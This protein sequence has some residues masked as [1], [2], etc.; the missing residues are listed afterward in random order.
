MLTMSYRLNPWLNDPKISVT[1]SM[2]TKH[3]PGE[4]L[5]PPEPNIEHLLG[6]RKVSKAK[7]RSAQGP[8]Q[9]KT[10]EEAYQASPA[11]KL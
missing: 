9:H 1:L 8:Q 7:P 11:G 2:P 3:R 4:P 5:D 6:D 10:P